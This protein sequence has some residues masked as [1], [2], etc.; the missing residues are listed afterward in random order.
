MKTKH[1]ISVLIG[2]LIVFAILWILFSRFNGQSE[3]KVKSNIHNGT[4]H[5]VSV[6]YINA[7]RADSIL[8]QVDG[9][10]F[11]ID[12]GLKSYT[13]KISEVLDKYKVDI[14]DAVFLTH[15]HSD[16]IGGLKKIAKNY[17]IDRIYAS[18][19]SVRDEDNQNEI[20]KIANKLNIPLTTL[21]FSERVK[22]V[23]DVYM[24]VLGPIELNEKDEND[25]SLVLSMN[26]NDRTF[27][28][29][30]DMQFAEEVTLMDKGVDVSADIYKI[31]NH[32]NPDA[33]LEEF[34]KKV[35]PLYAIVTTNTRIDKDSANKK[36]LSYFGRSKIYLTQD[37]NLGILV[38]VDSKGK[39][40]VSEA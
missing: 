36:V 23:D 14:F 4:K 29:S 17:R 8:V 40:K 34:A 35:S 21:V 1:T 2:V 30:G 18:Q 13:S 19:L 25:N 10:S 38:T 27:L 22:L 5:D 28:F 12:A 31:S 26:I 16:H 20:D 39:I 7:G 33:T 32:G 9:H 3:S 24:D 15:P 6:V 11:L 37:Y